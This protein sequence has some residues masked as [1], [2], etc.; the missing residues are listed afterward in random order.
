MEAT[1]VNPGFSGKAGK[2]TH[3]ARK[4]LDQAE[5]TREALLKESL[6][7]PSAL[8]GAAARRGSLVGAGRRRSQQR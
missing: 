6:P 8:P 5:R 4:K 1:S 7:T 3:M 2:S